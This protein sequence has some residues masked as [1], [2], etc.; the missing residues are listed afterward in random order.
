MKEHIRKWLLRWLD[1]YT[2]EDVWN[3]LGELTMTKVQISTLVTARV[4]EQWEH[5]ERQIR[6]YEQSL[7][8]KYHM[9][10]KAAGDTTLAIV[11]AM[12]VQAEIVA[13]LEAI[14]AEQEK[15]SEDIP[16]E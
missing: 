4:K 8:S 6:E 5:R 11:K 15:G 2:K 1:V 12:D 10:E 3:M 16:L 7:D 9:L 14:K 13:L